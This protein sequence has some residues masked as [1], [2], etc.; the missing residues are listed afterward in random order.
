MKAQIWVETVVYTL[1]GL[2]IIAVILALLTPKIQETK[3]KALID[4]SI[5]ILDS[6]SRTVDDIKFSPGNSWPLQVK[7]DKGKFFIDGTTDEIYFL[8][9]DSKIKYSEE[10]QEISR[11]KI[12]IKT[13]TLNRNTAV[14]LSLNYS[15]I[16]NITYKGKDESHSF[17]SASLPYDLFIENVGKDPA[18]NLTI[19]NVQ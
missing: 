16:L 11:G 18:T 15:K 7:F 12:K 3:D 5:S 9:D 13:T 4:Q 10:G 8:F 14:K 6:L 1:I 17:S 19:I 2:S